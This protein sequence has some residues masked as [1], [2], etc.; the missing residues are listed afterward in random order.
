MMKK[1][2]HFSKHP[3]EVFATWGVPAQLMSGHHGIFWENCSSPRT[4]AWL[5]RH[6]W[7]GVEA[8][9]LE[10]FCSAV[11]FVGWRVDLCATVVMKSM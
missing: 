7:L 2:Q 5:A 8:K 11:E 9:E 1:L 6:D 4:F 3:G 10:F